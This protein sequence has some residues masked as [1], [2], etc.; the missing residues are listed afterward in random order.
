MKIKTKFSVE[1]TVFLMHG[2]SAREAM[3]ESIKIEV[4]CNERH[5]AY[6]CV[7]TSQDFRCERG[8]KGLYKSRKAAIKAWVKEQEAEQNIN[9][10]HKDMLLHKAHYKKERIR[11]M[12][13]TFDNA[14]EAKN[15]FYAIECSKD[16]EMLIDEIYSAFDNRKCT[17]CQFSEV[18]TETQ[19]Y[20][21]EGVGNEIEDDNF[22]VAK[23]FHCKYFLRKG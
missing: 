3:V 8:E 19:C 5:T 16:G 22:I 6:R 13:D 11:N 1:D 14:E 23:D 4:Y 7:A 10:L 2:G 9:I 20:C 12:N 17:D 21:T 15:S 18:Y